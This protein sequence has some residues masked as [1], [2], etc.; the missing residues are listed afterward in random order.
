ML[1][2]CRIFVT[3]FP[4]E[5]LWTFLEEKK[6]SQPFQEFKILQFL[7]QQS[8]EYAI[9]FSYRLNLKKNKQFQYE[10]FIEL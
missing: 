1:A 3:G 7:S 4:P 10:M 5:T 8:A 9:T 6:F 2:G